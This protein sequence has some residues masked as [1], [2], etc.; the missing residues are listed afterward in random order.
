[1]RGIDQHE[2]CDAHDKLATYRKV[3]PEDLRSFDLIFHDEEQE[4]KLQRVSVEILD[5]D[6]LF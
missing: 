6:W 3:D 1:M 5:L 2:C 4:A